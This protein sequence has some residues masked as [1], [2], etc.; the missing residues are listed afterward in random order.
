M[1]DTPSSG[2]PPDFSTSFRERLDNAPVEDRLYRVALELTEPMRV[3][4]IATRAKCAPDTAR[5]Y[6]TLFVK[7]GVLNSVGDDPVRFERN[8]A[9]FEWRRQHDGRQ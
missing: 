9:Y 5:R 3:S 1:T 8:E 2:R 7:I 6:L 4:E